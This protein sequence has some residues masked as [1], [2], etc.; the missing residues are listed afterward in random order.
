[1]AAFRL[2]RCLDDQCRFLQVYQP[3]AP[4]VGVAVGLAAGTVG[5][6]DALVAGFAVGLGVAGIGVEVVPVVGVRSIV[7][8]VADT[9]GVVEVPAAGLVF[10]F[11]VFVFPA[12]KLALA[13]TP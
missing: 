7:G 1:M 11:C 3:P 6:G 12:L 8:F 13:A 4:V 9:V 5:E 2:V 10:W